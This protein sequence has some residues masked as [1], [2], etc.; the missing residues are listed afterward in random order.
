[1]RL[2]DL[3][4]T[5][6][7]DVVIL[8]GER[9][10]SGPRADH[11]ARALLN[12]AGRLGLTGARAGAG[13]LCVP[14]GTNGR[15]LAEV[16]VLPTA[17]PG[18]AAP[19]LEGRDTAQIAG[20]AAAGELLALYLLHVD[21]LRDLPHRALW[22]GALDKATT[23]IAHADFL[24][25]GIREHA[26]V[27]FPAESYAEK[28]GTL[29]HPDGRLQRLRPSIAHQGETLAEWAVLVEL[30]RRLGHE[31]DIPTGP[32]ATAA[33]A[34]AVPFYAGVTADEIGGKGVRWQDRDAASGFAREVELGPFALEPP[35]S[36]DVGADGRFRL[37][38]FRS[39]WAAPEVEAS[40]AL[41]F[42]HPRQRAELSP[43]DAQRM[44]VVEGDRV[45]VGSNGT[46]VRATVA[47]RDA[48]PEGSVF[49]QSSIPEDSASA[50]EGP[51][52]E[53]RKA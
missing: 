46:S 20:G 51:L 7:E 44:G 32:V 19:V 25:E 36:P 1:V 39:V 30:A 5:A 2:A 23:V 35:P 9:L 13:L 4:S 21:P 53:V 34:A 50:L 47:L 43:A 31:L 10:V 37:G 18:L 3:L 17:G 42:L 41:R 48:M 26:N 40:P 11:A 12:V 16:G 27:V 22:A 49:L 33:M 8:Y 52:V 15:G 14:S 6:G 24:T 29:T 38:T 45:V 28:E